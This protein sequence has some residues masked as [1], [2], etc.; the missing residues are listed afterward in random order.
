MPSRSVSSGPSSTGEADAGALGADRRAVV[1]TAEHRPL[2]LAGC[3]GGMSEAGS[4]AAAPAVVMAGCDDD[5]PLSAA[6]AY[7]A[8]RLGRSSHRDRPSALGVEEV[9]GQHRSIGHR[10]RRA[11]CGRSV[12]ALLGV[13]FDDQVL[14][15]AGEDLAQRDNEF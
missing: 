7:P 12:A 10:R 3:A 14:E 11:T 2:L 13:E 5:G 6:V 4:R 15:P 8:G 1:V 9:G